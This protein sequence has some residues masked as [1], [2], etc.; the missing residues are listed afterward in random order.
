M[1]PGENVEGFTSGEPSSALTGMCCS[2]HALVY[3]PSDRRGSE[4]IRP[5]SSTVWHQSKANIETILERDHPETPSPPH[6]REL[7]Q[8]LVEMILASLYSTR[9]PSKPVP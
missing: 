5:P 8:E 9:L 1:S 7:P 2:D 3:I 4:G 6:T